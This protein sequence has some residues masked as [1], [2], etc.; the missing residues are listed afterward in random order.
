MF[1]VALWLDREASCLFFK[2]PL[3]IQYVLH[4]PGYLSLCYPCYQGYILVCIIHFHQGFKSWNPFDITD[5]IYWIL[6]FRFADIN[7]TFYIQVLQ[8]NSTKLN[9]YHIEDLHSYNLYMFFALNSF[10]THLILET[11]KWKWNHGYHG[12]E[13]TRCLFVVSMIVNAMV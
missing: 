1:I 13:F 2:N 8:C 6:V 7:R 9:F 4:L 3:T 5:V 11:C 12:C 10:L